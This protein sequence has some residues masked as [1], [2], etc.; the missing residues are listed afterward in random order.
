MTLKEI[1]NFEQ[2]KDL[3]VINKKADLH[4]FVSTVES[5]E[6]PDVAAYVAKD[7]FIITTAMIYKDDQEKLCELIVRLNALPCAGLGIKIGRFVE[8][9]EP[10]VIETADAVGLPLISIP[11]YQTLGNVYLNILS[12]MW[13]TK[14]RQ[15]IEV[16]NAQRKYYDL[17]IHG[18]SLRHLLRI[19]GTSTKKNIQI[20]NRLGMVLGSYNIAHV[21]HQYATK[22]V[23]QVDK[24]RYAC[25]TEM[26]F[27]AVRNAHAETTLY[28]IKSIGKNMYYM[29][30]FDYEKAPSGYLMEEIVLIIGMYLYKEIILKYN[31]MRLR[32]DCM[33]LAT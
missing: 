2:L 6:T 33:K 12:I 26:Y 23:E 5:T 22:M 10:I 3:K 7:S 17:I 25:A 19:I 29:V 8:K 30:V 27:D 32:S 14:N 18:V 31:D 16:L 24:D 28:P 4:R 1:L 13:N 11:I 9:L 21:E 15:L 20:I